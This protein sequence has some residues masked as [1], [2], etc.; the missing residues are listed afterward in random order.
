M[1]GRL[2]LPSLG[3]RSGIACTRES[4]KSWTLSMQLQTPRSMCLPCHCQ[5][6]NGTL[7]G[8][9]VV[10]GKR[11]PWIDSLLVEDENLYLKG[12]RTGLKYN[13]QTEGKGQGNI[14][15]M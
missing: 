12:G 6:G 11:Q 2:A 15:G 9:T 1:V 3:M 4:L 14:T 8:A 10:I 7:S 5:M 13:Y